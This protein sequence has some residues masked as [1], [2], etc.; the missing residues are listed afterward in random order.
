ME[1]IGWNGVLATMK[2]NDRMRNHFARLLASALFLA[3][4]LA[5]ATDTELKV[6]DVFPDLSGFALEGEL[7]TGLPG[8]IMVVDFWAS[9]CGPCRRT[10]PLMEELHHRFA[11]Q[12]LVI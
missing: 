6:G 9:W 4:A 5:G 7:P 10:F 12:G 2:L 8:K 1:R 11:N 3:A